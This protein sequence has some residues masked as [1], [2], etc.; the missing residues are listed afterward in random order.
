MNWPIAASDLT[1]SM[2]IIFGIIYPKV[3]VNKNISNFDKDMLLLCGT[4]ATTYTK[5]SCFLPITSYTHKAEKAN[6]AIG[7]VI[8]Y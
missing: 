6:A 7:H 1:V 5:L 3:E 2:D 4:Y 8:F